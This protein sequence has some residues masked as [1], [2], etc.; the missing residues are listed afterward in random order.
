MIKIVN[1]INLSHIMQTFSAPP[2]IIIKSWG[3]SVEWWHFKGEYP[4]EANY[5][6]LDCTKTNNILKWKPI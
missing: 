3:R 5:L 2:D 6:K 1:E 4:H